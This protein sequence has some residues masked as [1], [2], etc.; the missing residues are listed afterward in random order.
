[1]YAI[2]S[3]YVWGLDLAWLDEANI[4]RGS[5]FMGTDIVDVVR[6]SFMPT[7]TI[8]DGALTGT[9]LTNTNKRI[10]IINTWLDPKTEVVLNSDHPSIAAMFSPSNPNQA[11]NWTQLLD[12]TRAMHVAAGRTVIT[13]S[14]FNEPDYSATGQSYNFV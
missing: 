8:I 6:S 2:R 9:A 4:I 13:V 14:P 7:D 5:R 10:D 1:M 12:V 3:Y 11:A